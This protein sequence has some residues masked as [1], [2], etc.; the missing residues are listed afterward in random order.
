MKRLILAAL[1]VALLALPAV[2]PAP[3]HDSRTA[4][5]DADNN[6]FTGLISPTHKGKGGELN[7][8]IYAA[9][10]WSATVSLQR[11]FDDGT[12]YITVK[13][14]TYADA[15]AAHDIAERIVDYEP[16]SRYRMGVATGDYTSGTIYLRLSK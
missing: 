15:T 8:S 11:T 13:E 12:T 4:T 6:T 7:V 5:V 2:A 14:Y 9:S 10:S 16:D 1:T 3:P